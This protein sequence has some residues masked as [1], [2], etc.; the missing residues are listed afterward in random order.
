MEE[1][2]KKFLQYLDLEVDISERPTKD[3]FTLLTD[4]I[5]GTEGKLRYRQLDI[6]DRLAAIRETWFMSLRKYGRLLGTVGFVRRQ[7]FN[8]KEKI[9]TYYIRYFSIKFSQVKKSKSGKSKKELTKKKT[10]RGSIIKE[11][12]EEFMGQ[13]E[14]HLKGVNETPSI[15][16]AY[17]EKENI[18]SMQMSKR[19]GYVTVCQMSQTYFSRF[20]PKQHPDVFAVRQEEKSVVLQKIRDFYKDYTLF[21]EEPLFYRNGYL[22]YRNQQ[23][24]IVA[25]IQ[26]FEVNWEIVEMPGITGWFFLKVLPYIPLLRKFYDGHGFR[27]VAFEGLFYERGYEHVLSVLF[28]SALCRFGLSLGIFWHDIKSPLVEIM[29]RMPRKGL[30]GKLVTAVPA[31]VRMRFLKMTPGH[32]RLYHE[33]PVYVSA[34]D[35]T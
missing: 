5:L 32:I 9:N 8:G 27:F 33:K 30:F 22:V 25:G 6:R 20:F 15:L 17:I 2:K 10:P 35:I 4:Y 3:I 7:A 23:G 1:K 24:E 11:Q 28:E 21:Q 26:A 16:Y 13:V 19:M 29:R 12:V 18:P 14:Q 31:D 34:F